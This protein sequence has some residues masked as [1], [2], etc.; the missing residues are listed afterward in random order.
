MRSVVSLRLQS[1]TLTSFAVAD[2]VGIVKEVSPLGEI[3]SKSTNKTVN[4]TS[5]LSINTFADS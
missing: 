3:T 2:V 5:Y 4:T 1:E